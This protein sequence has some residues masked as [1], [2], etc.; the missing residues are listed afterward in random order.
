LKNTGYTANLPELQANAHSAGHFNPDID[1]DG[2]YRRVPI[3]QDYKGA[4]YDA[5]PWPWS[6]VF[7]AINHFRLKLVLVV[8]VI[9]WNGWELIF[10]TYL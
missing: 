8:V 3:L 2:V 10:L 7:W 5:S 4:Y 1:P 6:A 9:N